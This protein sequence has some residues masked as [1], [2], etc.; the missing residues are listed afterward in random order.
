M[1]TAG[2]T[3]SDSIRRLPQ[4][5]VSF[6]APS[7]ISPQDYLSLGCGSTPPGSLQTDRKKT[8]TFSAPVR[9]KNSGRIGLAWGKWPTTDS[10][11]RSLWP[12]GG[13]PG[14]TPHKQ[15]KMLLFFEP[16]H[17]LLVRM[18]KGTFPKQEIQC[19]WQCHSPPLSFA[20]VTLGN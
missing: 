11:P 5:L 7:A 8:S 18:G 6:I 17:T 14:S 4:P 12:E 3:A 13:V 1:G 9:Q 2:S 16:P 20:C 15:D 10:S 19:V